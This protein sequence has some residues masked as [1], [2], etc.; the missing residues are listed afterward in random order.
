M[1]DRV[2]ECGPERLR[3][4]AGYGSEQCYG[5]VNNCEKNRIL[6]GAQ[7]CEHIRSTVLLEGAAELDDPERQADVEQ[8]RV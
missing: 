3:Y 5:F 1:N 2:R 8:N 7:M 4:D 6:R